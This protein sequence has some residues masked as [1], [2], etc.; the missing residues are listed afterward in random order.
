M[1]DPRLGAVAVPG[2]F[3]S[4]SGTGLIVRIEESG[5][6]GFAIDA[7]AEGPPEPGRDTA[8]RGFGFGGFDG[9]ET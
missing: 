3:G 7:A 1:A 4:E 2:R 9:K 8:G 5:W 6:F